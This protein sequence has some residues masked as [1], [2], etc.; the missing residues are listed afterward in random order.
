MGELFGSRK[1]AIAEPRAFLP[2]FVFHRRNGFRATIGQ[3]L[4]FLRG[5]SENRF[6]SL[7]YKD[8]LLRRTISV[9]QMS[10]LQ[11]SPPGR[12]ANRAS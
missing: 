3:N 2:M 11:A 4:V 5:F 12:Y 7:I 8:L 6:A 1:P 10:K 9:F